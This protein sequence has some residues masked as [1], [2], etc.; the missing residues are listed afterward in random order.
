MFIVT[1]SHINALKRGYFTNMYG[2]YIKK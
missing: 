2:W 1:L